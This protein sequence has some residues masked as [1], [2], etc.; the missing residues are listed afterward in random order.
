MR[1]K[2]NA[3]SFF[4]VVLRR[5]LEHYCTHIFY[6]R[7]VVLFLQC[8]EKAS[9]LYFYFSLFIFAL[10]SSDAPIVFATFGDDSLFT[11]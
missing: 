10:S 1:R 5:R 4:F 2:E 7:F 8:M 11:E 9:F 3:I 6:F